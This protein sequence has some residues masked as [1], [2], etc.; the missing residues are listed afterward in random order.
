MKRPLSVSLFFVLVFFA[1][2]FLYA[3]WPQS[4]EPM[5]SSVEIKRALLASDDYAQNKEWFYYAAKRMIRSRTCTL[6]DFI[7]SDGWKRSDPETPGLYHVSCKSGRFSSMVVHF[8]TED[9]LVYYDKPKDV[10]E[11]SRLLQ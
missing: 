3:R 4:M 1:A 11:L 7:R 9:Q 10:F 8:R 6:Q 5:P 2:L